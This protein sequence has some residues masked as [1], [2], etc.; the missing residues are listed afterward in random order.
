MG[1]NKL[2]GPRKAQEILAPATFETYI[3]FF[4]RNLWPIRIQNSC[5]RCHLHNALC[6]AC[7]GS[8]PG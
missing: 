5:V 1:S 3:K 8:V 6:V 7:I 2:N 4:L